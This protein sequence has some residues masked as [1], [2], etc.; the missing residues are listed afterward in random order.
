MVDRLPLT[1]SDALCL[2]FI[3]SA[4]LTFLPKCLF[5]IAILFVSMGLFMH[6]TG[7]FHQAAEP[8][9][10]QVVVYSLLNL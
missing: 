5:L 8:T 9:A 6:P 3:T 2:R 7:L 10:G 4:T 1:A